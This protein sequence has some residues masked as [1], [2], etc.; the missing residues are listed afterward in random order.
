LNKIKQLKIN[1][2]KKKLIEKYSF[3][4]IV[5]INYGEENPDDIDFCKLAHN[6][7]NG[8]YFTYSI[9]D[10]GSSFV[11]ENN[12]LPLSKKLIRDRVGIFRGVDSLVF[13]A[14]Y[15][16]ENFRIK[17]SAEKLIKHFDEIEDFSPFPIIFDENHTVIISVMRLEYEVELYIWENRNS[18]ITK[19]VH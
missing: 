7:I 17:C 19:E 8:E 2:Y 13:T 14:N 16:S 15:N 9:G 10:N 12:V 6:T 1:N 3:L 18:E 11:N 5:D 4:D